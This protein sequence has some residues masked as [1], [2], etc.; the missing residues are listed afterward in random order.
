MAFT[1]IQK[2]KFKHCDPAG[3]VFYPRFFE[4]TNDTVEAFFDEV[5]SFPFSEMHQRSGIPTAQIE[6][7]FKAPSRLGDVLR[8]VMTCE[9]LG[10]TSLD[11]RFVA[12]CGEDLRFTASATLVLVDNTGRPTAWSGHVRQVLEEQV[13]GEI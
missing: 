12:G 4:M 5:L 11:I 2:V 13:K 6:A 1:Y 7:Q 10:R 9:R 8:I 3:I